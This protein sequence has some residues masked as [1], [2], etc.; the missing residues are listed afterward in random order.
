MY[1]GATNYSYNLAC[2]IT[3]AVFTQSRHYADSRL[4]R[5][6]ALLAPGAEDRFLI[7]AIVVVVVV[8]ASSPPRRAVINIRE[9]ANERA[10]IRE[11]R[12]TSSILFGAL[13][14]FCISI[15]FSPVNHFSARVT[16]RDG[17]KVEFD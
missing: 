5:A 10:R 15:P 1:A 9:R 12:L 4:W 8:V 16:R 17:E 13:I 14:R 6:R 3:R 7:A 11:T 2:L